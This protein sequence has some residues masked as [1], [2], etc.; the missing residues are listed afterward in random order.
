MIASDSD[1]SF[2]MEGLADDEEAVAME[3]ITSTNDTIEGA[4]S[5]IVEFDDVGWNSGFGEG[6]FH[7][8]G[9]VVVLVAI[10]S[11]DEDVFHNSCFSEVYD[12]LDAVGVE[13]VRSAVTKCG[14]C[15][16]KKNRL[17]C[18]DCFYVLMNV[19]FTTL[20]HIII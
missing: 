16:K 7:F 19:S 9:F 5:C 4:K 13:K 20:L 8:F 15:T 10:I 3:D 1:G 6:L 18:A 17:T 11:A 14:C 2:Y 12:G